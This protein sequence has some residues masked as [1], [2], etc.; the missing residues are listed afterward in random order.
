MQLRVVGGDDPQAF[1]AGSPRHADGVRDLQGREHEPIALGLLVLAHRRPKDHVLV[2]DL[3]RQVGAV[4]IA[5]RRQQASDELVVDP[6]GARDGDQLA[7]LPQLPEQDL[8]R[9]DQVGHAGGQQAVE[10]VE[11][12]PGAQIRGDGGEGLDGEPVGLLQPLGA[13]CPLFGHEAP[14]FAELELGAHVHQRLHQRLPALPDPGELNLRRHVLG[15]EGDR[16]PVRHGVGL[17]VGHD[18]HSEHGVARAKLGS[19][20]GWTWRSRGAAFHH[21]LGELAHRIA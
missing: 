8:L 1:V 10:V 5:R 15:E 12:F 17:R 18:D 4:W 16:L 19:D 13:A 7:I 11:A 20:E 9:A 21:A 3:A 14:P 6:V 2:E